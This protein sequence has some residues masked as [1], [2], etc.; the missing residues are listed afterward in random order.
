MATLPP[1]KVLSV[2]KITNIKRKCIIKAY[3]HRDSNHNVKTSINTNGYIG[4]AL[5]S[6]GV[7]LLSIFTHSKP[8]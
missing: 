7:I 1:Q 3:S 6:V 4:F 8:I 5:G 2:P